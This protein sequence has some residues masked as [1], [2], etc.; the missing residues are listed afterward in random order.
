MGHAGLNTL[1]Q[2]ETRLL[3][4]EERIRERLATDYDPAVT[5][6]QTGIGYVVVDE[7]HDFKNLHT[8][9]RIPSAAIEGS[10]RAADLEMKMHY[11]RRRH[12]LRVGRHIRHAHPDRQSPDGG[13]PQLK[14]RF[15]KFHNVPELLRMWWVCGNVK[16]AEDL[17]PP[18]PGLF[19]RPEDGKRLPQTMTVPASAEL[20]GFMSELAERAE[21]VRSRAVRPEQDNMLRISN[22]GR[23]AALDMRLVGHPMTPGESK[24]RPPPTRAPTSGASTATTASPPRRHCPPHARGF[25]IVFCDLSTPKPDERNAYDEL[26]AQLA[27]RGV[28]EERVQFIH[29]ACNDREK[30]ELFEACRTR[31]W[32]RRGC[33]VAA[34]GWL[35]AVADAE[36]SSVALELLTKPSL[37]LLNL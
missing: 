32:F 33:D 10:N 24:S 7:A 5:F 22:H 1:M 18:R 9:S 6:E 26:R 17:N 25:H 30:A 15:A 29:E 13:T 19:A 4:A 14:A 37:L 16:T 21:W 31:W 8:A 28:P 35:G 2:L 36:S 34:C 11:L 27:T 12:G 20:V 3:T 23:A